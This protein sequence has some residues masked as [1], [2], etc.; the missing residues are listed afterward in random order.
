MSMKNSSIS[1]SDLKMLKNAKSALE[2]PNFLVKVSNLIGSPFE[3]TLTYLPS[4]IQEKI[5]STC[6]TALNKSAEIALWSLSSRANKPSNFSHKALATLSGG[7]GGFFGWGGFLCEIPLSTTIIMRSIC[8]IAKAYGE[9][10]SLPESKLECL[11]IFSLGG[12]SN[13]DD[14]SDT[15]YYI[16]RSSLASMIVDSSKYLTVKKATKE[17]GPTLIKL[18]QTIASKFSLQVSEKAIAMSLPIIGAVGGA[19]INAM[20]ISYYQQIAEGHFAMRY[21]ERKYGKEKIKE[22]YEKINV[23]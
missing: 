2:S 17:I 10:L 19:T 13:S 23:R 9:D 21:L 7:I 12:K 16:I 5:N 22:I 14:I 4:T 8:E 11:S 6:Y 18:L 15:G 20:F 1:F 3:H